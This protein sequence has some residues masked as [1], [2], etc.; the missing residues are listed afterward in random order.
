MLWDW[1]VITDDSFRVFSSIAALLTRLTRQ[2]L[3]FQWSDE[4]EKS[5]QNLKT[6]LTSSP[7]F[8]LPEGV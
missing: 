3:C 7:M 6:L 8:T 5:F 2:G 4:C 1:Q